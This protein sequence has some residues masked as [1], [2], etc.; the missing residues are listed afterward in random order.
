MHYFD[1]IFE[2]GQIFGLQHYKACRVLRSSAL[3]EMR[4]DE[5]IQMSGPDP[6]FHQW[7]VGALD[8]NKP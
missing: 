4:Q 1:K 7:L 6:G 5:V 2:F 8:W 3:V